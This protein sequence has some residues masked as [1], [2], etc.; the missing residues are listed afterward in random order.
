MLL[1][2]R[3]ATSVGDC[4]LF[5]KL[6]WKTLK[7]KQSEERSR[8]SLESDFARLSFTS[9]FLSQVHST[10]DRQFLFPSSGRN[11]RPAS[12]STRTCDLQ[13]RKRT[14]QLRKRP[15]RTNRTDNELRS[16]VLTR[17]VVGNSTPVLPRITINSHTEKDTP[18]ATTC[19]NIPQPLQSGEVPG[20]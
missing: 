5:L 10:L 20:S 3:I 18:K 8:D 2:C 12:N 15:R 16:S 11:S 4:C 17:S 1:N 19:G 14:R 13:R 6:A 7:C 9:A